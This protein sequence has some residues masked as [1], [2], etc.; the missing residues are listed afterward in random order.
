MIAK[1]L[2]GIAVACICEVLVVGWLNYEYHG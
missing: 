2:K 1:N